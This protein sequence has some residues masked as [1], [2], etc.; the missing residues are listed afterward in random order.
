MTA[1]NQN[2][3]KTKPTHRLVRVDNHPTKT[4]EQGYPVKVYTALAA[5]WITKN[6]NAL[7]GTI[8]ALNAYT[9]ALPQNEKTKILIRGRTPKRPFSTIL[10]R[11]S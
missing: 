6:G 3:A 1:S 10:S 9:L 2:T 5:L 4:D 11:F 7:S 8:G